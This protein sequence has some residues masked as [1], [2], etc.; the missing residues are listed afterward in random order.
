LGASSSVTTAAWELVGI[1][2]MPAVLR[3]TVQNGRSVRL[4]WRASTDDVGVV[5]Y[6]VFRN[7][8][9]IGSTTATFMVD[10]PG[11]GRFTYRV[12]ARDADANVS[13]LSLPVP[14]TL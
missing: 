10:R 7:G 6:D 13:K 1:P 12:R 5:G 2:S 9:K 11:R 14:V 3:A 8:A 4:T